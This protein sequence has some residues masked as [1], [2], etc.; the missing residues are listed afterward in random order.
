MSSNTKSMLVVRYKN[1]DKVENKEHQFSV[2]YDILT[3]SYGERIY[4]NTGN[5]DRYYSMSKNKIYQK[6][7][8]RFWIP[9]S[10]LKYNVVG[11]FVKDLN[12][13]NCAIFD[14]KITQL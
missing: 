4:F 12:M 13:K 8:D 14:K 1:I 7:F 11:V 5:K 3:Y 6:I 9:I 10:W 2:A